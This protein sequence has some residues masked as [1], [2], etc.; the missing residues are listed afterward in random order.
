[1]SRKGRKLTDESDEDE[2]KKTLYQTSTLEPIICNKLIKK[3]NKIFT[4]CAYFF[5]LS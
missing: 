3:N 5:G 2:K 1:M 4:A